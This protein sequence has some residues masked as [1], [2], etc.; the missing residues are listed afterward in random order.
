MKRFWLII[1]LLIYIV[2]FWGI[3]SIAHLYIDYMTPEYN[4]NVVKTGNYLMF[5]IVTTLVFLRLS[6]TRPIRYIRIIILR[7]L[8]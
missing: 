6:Y 3:F 5:W 4:T 8:R 7:V 2:I 1:T